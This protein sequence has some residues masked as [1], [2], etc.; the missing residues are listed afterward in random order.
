MPPRRA[1]RVPSRLPAFCPTGVRLAPGTAST[2][3]GRA[4]RAERPR[5]MRPARSRRAGAGRP[6]SRLRSAPGAAPGHR[7]GRVHPERR[8]SS[9]DRSRPRHR[10]QRG[11]DDATATGSAR[12]AGEAGRARPGHAQRQPRDPRPPGGVTGEQQPPATS[13]HAGNGHRR[14]TAGRLSDTTGAEQ[15][16]P[17]GERDHP[18]IRVGRGQRAGRADAASAAA[19]AALAPRPV[20]S[21]LRAVGRAGTTS[22]PARRRE[23][24]QR[25]RLIGRPTERREADYGARTTGDTANAL[26]PATWGTSATVRASGQPGAGRRP[27][28]QRAHGRQP[29]YTP[30]ATAATTPIPGRTRRGMGR[31]PRR[32]VSR[33]AQPVR[34]TMPD[35]TPSA[36]PFRPRTSTGAPAGSPRATDAVTLALACAVARPAGAWSRSWAHLRYEF[37]DFDADQAVI[38]LMAK[39]FGEGR[40]VRALSVRVRLRAGRSTR[41]WPRRWSR[42]FGASVAVVRDARAPGQHRRRVP[43]S[44]CARAR[45]PAPPWLAFVGGTA[46]DAAFADAHRQ[47][48]VD[49]RRKRRAARVRPAD[50]DAAWR[51]RRVRRGRRVGILT[52]EFTAYGVAALLAIDLCD[53]RVFT[54]AR[55]RFY[56][57]ATLTAVVFFEGVAVLRPHLDRFGP[58]GATLAGGLVDSVS[59]DEARRELLLRRPPRPHGTSRTSSAPTSAKYMGVAEVPDVRAG[60]PASQARGPCSWPSSR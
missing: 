28:F 29:A 18:G 10:R 12:H 24:G 36:W 4:D 48:D 40:A 19:A 27:R 16:R 3:R 33:G 51:R 58:G 50:L 15:E 49:A 30:P 11:R 22:A 34:V 39:H 20:P 37:L 14:W 56:A 53:G 26:A 44:R 6:R 31:G 46:R 41:G 13:G 17:A 1:D 38:G 57:V 59:R 23:R 9:R 43:R 5:R 8:E 55:L 2:P 60:P 21:V 42:L 52:R 35:N 54:A 45:G 25:P 47:P 7:Q 32:A